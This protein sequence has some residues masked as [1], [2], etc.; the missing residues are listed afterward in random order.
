M[1]GVRRV[2]LVETAELFSLL[3]VVVGCILYCVILV[4]FLTRL[5]WNRTT[6]ES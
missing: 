6:E 4:I 3:I 2:W 1:D 5:D